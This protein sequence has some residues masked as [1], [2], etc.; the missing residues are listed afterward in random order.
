MLDENT[1]RDFFLAK[2]GA[3]ALAEEAS[4]AIEQ[5]DQVNQVVHVRESRELFPVN[6]AMLIK[7]CDSVLDG[8]LPASA[9]IPIGFVLETSERLEWGDD[10]VMSEVLG[11]WSAPEINYPL[12]REHIEMFKRWLL[13]VEPCPERESF[14]VNSPKGPLIFRRRRVTV[15]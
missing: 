7:L 6:R 12:N 4:T 14:P 13:N 9:L 10:D 5:V 11:D 3:S 8:A 1:L 15:S 2:I